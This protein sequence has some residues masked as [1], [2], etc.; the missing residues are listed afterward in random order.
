MHAM[1][2]RARGG[3][4]GALTGR[5]AFVLSADEANPMTELY[6]GLAPV[7]CRTNRPR[8]ALQPSPALIA[9]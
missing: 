9:A 4:M 6:D 2:D 8:D 5:Y 3:L 7:A 1:I